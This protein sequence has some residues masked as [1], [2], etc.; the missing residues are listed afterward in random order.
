MRRLALA[1]VVVAALAGTLTATAAQTTTPRHGSAIKAPP[2]R[3]GPECQAV[4]FGP[5]ARWAFRLD[6][7][8][9]PHPSEAALKRKRHRLSCAPSA[10]HRGAMLRKWVDAREALRVYHDYRVITPFDG[11]CNG[12]PP[13]PA[14]GC[15][16]AIPWSIVCA[17]GAYQIIPSTWASAGGLAYAPTAGAATPMAQHIIAHR[18]WGRTPWYGLC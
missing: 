2:P 17:D 10:T 12:S 13:G 6:R 3:P 8:R 16:W 14:D 15:H 1:A 4:N 5:F 18:L 9:H 7:W 11:P